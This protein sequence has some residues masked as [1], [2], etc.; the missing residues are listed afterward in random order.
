MSIISVEKSHHF[1]LTMAQVT[2]FKVQNFK[3][4]L[5]SLWILP[6]YKASQNLCSLQY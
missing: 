5:F 4:I 6:F 1:V 3:Y 2:N